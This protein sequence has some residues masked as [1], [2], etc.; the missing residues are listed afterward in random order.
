MS[1]IITDGKST[2]TIHVKRFGDGSAG[3]NMT[4]ARMH[5]RLAWGDARCPK[6]RKLAVIRAITYCPTADLQKSEEG[7]SLM[8]RL[9][10]DNNG[11][12]PIIETKYGKYIKLGEYFACGDCRKS[13]MQK[14]AKAPSWILVDWEELPQM[15]ARVQVQ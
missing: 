9:A 5:Q 1:K 12:V 14:L 10:R 13:M 7:V 8:L 11:N 2:E 15:N 4:P 3:H 6:C